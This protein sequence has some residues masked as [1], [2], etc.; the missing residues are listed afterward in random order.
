MSWNRAVMAMAE[1]PRRMLGEGKSG[2]NCSV[3]S[4]FSGGM[5]QSGL[6]PK[7]SEKNRVESTSMGE[8]RRH[9]VIP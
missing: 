3:V 8:T 2:R 6:E 5:P 4:P 1:F 7:D 9:R